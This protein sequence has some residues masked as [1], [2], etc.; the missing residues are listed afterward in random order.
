MV[1]RQSPIGLAAASA[2]AGDTM[3]VRTLEREDA[4]ACEAIVRALPDWF[5]LEEG[6]A[7]A[8]GYLETQ[9]G[10]VADD[11]GTVVG[12]LTYASE[13]AES[14][15]ITWMAVAADAHRRGIGRALTEAL[16]RHASSRKCELLLVKTL[17]D[18]DPSPEYEATRRFYRAMGFRPLTVLP[19]L[20]GP[21]NPCLLMVR[22]LVRPSDR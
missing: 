3:K 21:D 11:G 15:E 6:I 22:S 20:W 12:F 14:M 13:Y 4:D 8:R 7:E 16:V 17:A 9:D 5:G 10:F 18:S 1:L 2:S 19:D